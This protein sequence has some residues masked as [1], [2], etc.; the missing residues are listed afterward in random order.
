[1]RR[2]LL[3]LLFISSLPATAQDGTLD[4]TFSNDGMLVN[5]LF[6]YDDQASAVLVQP[7]GR[8]L[9]AGWTDD[10]T[11]VFLA[12][13]R[14]LDNG[15]PDP[16]FGV[17]GTVLSPLAGHLRYAY[18]IGL[19][20]TGA[21]VVAGLDYD[22]NLDG[23]ALLMRYLPDG[24]LDDSFGEGG[25]TSSDLG[26]GPGFQS[27]WAMRVLSD[28]RIVVV[29]EQGENGVMCAR[30]TADGE[31]DDTFGENGVALSGI[32]FGSGLAVAVQ[33]DGSILAGG[34]RIAGKGSD[35][36]IAR[37]RADG[38][39][40]AGFGDAGVAIIDVLGGDVETL[41]SLSIMNDG[42]I[43]ACGYRGSNG[44]DYAPVV[45][46]LNAN[47]TLDTGFDEVG[48]RVFSYNAPQWGQARSIIAQPDGKLLVAGFRVE[49]GETENNDFF[50]MRLLPDGS[51]D[52]TFAEGGRVHTDLSGEQVRALAMTLDNEDRIVLAGYGTG[53]QRAFG[54]ARYANTITTTVVE[55]NKASTL[56]IYPTPATDRI[57][58]RGIDEQK[59]AVIRLFHADGRSIAAQR[60]YPPFSMDLPVELASGTYLLRVE[61]DGNTNTR[62]VVVVR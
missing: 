34:Y 30:F 3:Q 33:N 14:L 25:V 28:D 10:G 9:T 19:Q 61:Q 55:T 60:M 40:D 5:D 42:R 37:F 38:T 51:F 59:P 44:Q 45:A 18:D 49:P 20:S 12:L 53:D 22:I 23:N 15:T 31:L 47:G 36:L 1:M 6:F 27:A 54:Y 8:I 62:P 2:T 39:L 11:Q 41:E 32:S 57:S 24:T 17:G 56:T 13:Q 16:G 29:G 26:S 35:W 7:D 21:I 46:L 50:L 58:V 4:P 48:F 43:A 52:G